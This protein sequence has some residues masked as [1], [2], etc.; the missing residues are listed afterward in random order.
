MKNKK[1]KNIFKFF[2]C[3]ILAT[4]MWI[5]VKYKKHME[6]QSQI[7]KYY[8]IE[9]QAK[10]KQAKESQKKESKIKNIS[11]HSKKQKKIPDNILP[12]TIIGIKIDTLTSTTTESQ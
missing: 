11:S 5:T 1:I 3:M 7:N 8:Q 10:E 2:L 4:G 12:D 9:K 6:E